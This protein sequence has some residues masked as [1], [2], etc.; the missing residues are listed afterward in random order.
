MKEQT[1]QLTPANGKLGILIPGL[2]AVATTLIAGVMAARKGLAQPIGSLTQMGKIR[3]RRE[4]GDNN[5]KI[6]DFVPLADLDS[7]EFGGWD[8]YEDN[9]FEAAL[10][11]KVLEPMTLHAVR[12]E[13]EAIVPMTAAFDKHYAKNLTGT[14]IKE[15]TTKLDLAEQVRADIR[16]FK[17][18]RGCSRLVMVWCGSTEIYHE[19]SETHHTITRR[20]HP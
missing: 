19:P 1:G 2:G 3:L 18:E 15:F 20:L 6:K 14:H 16:N 12:Q 8:V 10:K 9:V 17:A 11:A 4:V 13:M 5:P 7:L